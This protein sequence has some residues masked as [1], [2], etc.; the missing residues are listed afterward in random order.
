MSFL[1]EGSAGQQAE[2]FALDY[3]LAQG[4][5]LLERNYHSRSGE[6]DLVMRDGSITVFVE[7]RYRS[8]PRHG[9]AQESVTRTKQARIIKT[10]TYYCKEKRLQS[11]TRFDVLAL[12][13]TN[14]RFHAQWIKDAFRIS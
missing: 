9:S 2:D 12:N 7:V 11:T 1:K 14:G 13:S 6:I 8:N 5:V 10:A 3:L 4:L